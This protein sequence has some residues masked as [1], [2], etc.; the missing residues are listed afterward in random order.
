MSSGENFRLAIATRGFR[1]G[2]LG[3]RYV[4]EQ[5]TLDSI[6]NVLTVNIEQDNY[7]VVAA[8]PEAINASIEV[9]TFTADIYEID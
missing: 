2:G 3:T 8:L 4:D 9:Q 7:S 1:G 6:E 5:I